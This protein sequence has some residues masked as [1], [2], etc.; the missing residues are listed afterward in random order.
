MLPVQVLI[1]GRVYRHPEATKLSFLVTTW[2]QGS[3]DTPSDLQ[4]VTGPVTRA[5]Q[6]LLGRDLEGPDQI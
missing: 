5:D 4:V 1:A 2:V 6:E 3:P